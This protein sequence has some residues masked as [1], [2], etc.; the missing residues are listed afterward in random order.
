MLTIAGGCDISDCM[1]KDYSDNR[2]FGQGESSLTKAGWKLARLLLLSMAAAGLSWA[3]PAWPSAAAAAPEPLQPHI[4]RAASGGTLVLPPGEYAGPARIDKPLRLDGGG[5][6]T[7]TAGEA[8]G[9]VLEIAAD[10]TSVQGLAIEDIRQD[11][12][13]AAVLIAASGTELRDVAIRTRSTGVH[14]REAHRNRIEDVRIEW[15]PTGIAKTDQSFARKGNGIDLLNSHAN[16]IAGCRI[17][18]MFD[19]VYVESGD[20]NRIENNVVEQSRYGYHAMFAGHTTIVGNRGDRNVTGAMVMS[21]ADAEV[22]DNVFVKQSE[23][24]NSQGILLFD[25]QRARI[26]DNRLE[27]N[28][29][30]LYVERADDSLIQGNALVRNFI[31]LDMALAERNEIAGNRFVANVTQAMAA[32]GTGNTVAGNYWDDFRGIDLS[33]RGRSDL[34]YRVNPFFQTLVADQAAFQLF[35]QSPGMIL[36][37]GLF[38][39]D[40]ERWLSDAQPLMH[41]PGPASAESSGPAGERAAIFGLAAGMLVLT[42]AAITLW[43]VKRT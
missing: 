7:L 23:N 17:S 32:A 6:V 1:R 21:S 10:G 5:R 8:D 39:G 28:R 41:P 22:R 11:K 34:P 31:G 29:V 15:L 16:V 18:G 40:K 19:A 30:G 35:F 27:G 42:A 37:E 9:P 26:A 38:Q 24:V 14:L 4:D 3:A 43:G 2:I 13:K 33:G 36:L 12:T 20:D 25:V